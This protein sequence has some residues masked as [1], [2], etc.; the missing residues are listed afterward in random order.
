MAPRTI[1]LFS[2]EMAL[3]FDLARVETQLELIAW[4]DAQLEGITNQLEKAFPAL[5]VLIENRVSELSMLEVGKAHANLKRFS[6]ALIGPWADEQARI[7]VERAQESLKDVLSNIP[8]TQEYR[9]HVT[10]ALPAVAGVGLIAASVLGLPAVVSYATI[11]TTSLLV[12]STSMVSTPVLLAG[13]AVLAGLSFAGVKVIDSAK[14]KTRAH[15]VARVNALART[16]VFG[17]GQAPQARCLL[18]DLQAAVLKAG[19]TQIAEVC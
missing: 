4:R 6:A 2:E 14:D 8:S 3:N 7:A 12:F 1:A 11:T 19:Q 13:G 5:L 18:N 10:A 17:Q 16:A 9:A 15:L